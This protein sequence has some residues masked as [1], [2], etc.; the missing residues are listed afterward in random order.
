MHVTVKVRD[1]F[2]LAKEML[3]D[4][5]DYVEVSILGPE[6]EFD[7]PASLHFDASKASMPE[8]GV[9]YEELDDISSTL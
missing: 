7:C 2:N 3:D 1:L 6:P 4:G 5:M 9:D 8:M